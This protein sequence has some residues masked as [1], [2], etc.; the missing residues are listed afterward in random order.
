MRY[1]AA[2]RVEGADT[3]AQMWARVDRQLGGY[4]AFDN[5]SDRP[6]VSAEWAH[7]SITLPVA[8]DSQSIY[9]GVMIFGTG[10]VWVDDVTLEAIGTRRSEP[11]KG[12]R[13]LTAS[14]LD[15][16]IAFGRLAGYVRYFHPSDVLARRLQALFD[17]IAPT[18]RLSGPGV[19]PELAPELKRE[20]LAG[21]SVIRWS[22]AGLGLATEP[23]I[24][25]SG[26]VKAA[27]SAGRLSV[28]IGGPPRHAEHGRLRWRH[29]PH[30]AGDRTLWI[31]GRPRGGIRLPDRR[32]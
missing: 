25:R 7:H 1:V 32:L 11:P 13:P 20:S 23:G 18:V 16:L 22:H 19:A 14:A 8:P 29:P 9:I 31:A 3:R 26:R 30:E 15:N 28:G 24:Y 5:M 27:V 17:P 2:V 6:I 10:K 21:L 12:P 4:S